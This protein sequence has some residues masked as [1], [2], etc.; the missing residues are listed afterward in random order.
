M[1]AF[2]SVLLGLMML[3][4]VVSA[5]STIPSSYLVEGVPLY[6]QI[7][8]KGCGAASLQMVFDFY[9]PFIEQM[10]IYDAARS[11]GTAL[12]DMARAGQFSSMSTTAG[13]RYVLGITTGYTGR[14]I[15]YAGFYYATTEPWLDGLKGIVSQGYPVIVLV[16][17]LPDL[18]GPH[19]RVVV[20]Y[21]DVAGVVKM[22][23]PWSREF[24]ND[25]DYVGSSSQSANP[26]AWDL[27]FGTFDMTYADFLDVWSLPTTIW[28]VP[29]LAYGAVFVAPWEIELT[30]PDSVSPG[31]K[32]TVTADITYPCPAPFGSDAFPMFTASG[33]VA[34]LTVGSDLSIVGDAAVDIEDV[35]AAGQHIK[36]SWTVKA[37][38][39]GGVYSLSVDATGIVSGSLDE[40]H[41]YPAYDYTDVIGGSASAS[42]SFGS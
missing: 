20:G 1:A 16:D 29:D 18:Y 6:Q 2:S 26:N 22:N 33:L 23:D 17:W 28:G 9:G 38:S 37:P 5:G 30:V 8:A 7:D 14:D 21:D 24:K 12:P 15:G 10:E 41:D 34:T 39:T 4:P 11:G 31:K 3:L 35:L 27:E 19:Y 25:M 42:V 40:W 36:V 32:F 13:D